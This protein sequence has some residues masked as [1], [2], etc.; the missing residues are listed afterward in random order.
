MLSAKVAS[1]LVRFL[2]V[3]KCPVLSR[4][5]RKR[6]PDTYPSKQQK[7]PA[8]GPPFRRDR[9]RALPLPP[10]SSERAIVMRTTVISKRLF[11]GCVS[12]VNAAW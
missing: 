11:L 5:T 6:F 9:R 8:P 12:K 10:Y 4:Q 3:A 1:G 7:A 2:D